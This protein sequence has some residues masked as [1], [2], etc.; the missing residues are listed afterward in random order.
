MTIYAPNFNRGA[1]LVVE[2]AVAVRIL[3]EVT[4]DTVHPFFQMNVIQMNCFLE[5]IRIVRR[6]DRVLRIEQVAFSIALEYLP[7]HPAM[8]VKISE[9]SALQLRVEF[10]RAGLV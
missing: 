8:S 7:K 3:P 9:L 4:V 10:R 5:S 1:R 6:N 2:N